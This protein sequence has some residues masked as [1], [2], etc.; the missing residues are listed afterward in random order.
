MVH[1]PALFKLQESREVELWD[2]FEMRQIAQ[3][4]AE[5][6][7]TENALVNI[8]QSFEPNMGPESTPNGRER[9]LDIQKVM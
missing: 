8:F 1:M 2:T 5:E 6:A 7:I 9:A 3:R 4:E